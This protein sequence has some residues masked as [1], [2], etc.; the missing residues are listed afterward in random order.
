[1]KGADW[2]RKD[3]RPKLRVH[4][5][6]GLIVRCDTTAGTCANQCGN[7]LKG[8]NISARSWSSKLGRAHLH[9]PI[10]VYVDLAPERA[11][12]G[13]CAKLL[14]TLYG[15]PSAARSWA[16]EYTRTMEDAGFVTG[17]GRLRV[18]SSMKRRISEWW[19]TVMT[20]SSRSGM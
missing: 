3:F 9:A 4:N 2:W 11:N 5:A 19:Y 6:E 1:M 12:W 16:K 15:L 18:L 10:E 8:G 20:S 17:S 14:V 13:K 7:E